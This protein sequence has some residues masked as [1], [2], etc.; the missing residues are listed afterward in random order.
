LRPHLCAIK[1][2][3][4]KQ[5]VIFLKTK[6]MKSLNLRSFVAVLFIAAT[7]L[8]SC[9]KESVPPP[10]PHAPQAGTWTGKYGIGQSEPSIYFSFVINSNG[11][12]QV[13][14]GNPDNPA[15]GTGTWKI[16]EQGSF[17]AVYYYNSTPADKFNVYAAIDTDAGN[18]A[19]EWG[20]GEQPSFKGHFYMHR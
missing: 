6:I 9:K 14:K 15:L 16:D 18:M 1:I 5:S 17:K 10:V 3:K 12:L 13:K 8:I 4:Q 7:S 2:N 20:E 11:T 19:G